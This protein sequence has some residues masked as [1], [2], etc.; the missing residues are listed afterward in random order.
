MITKH[1][2]V[3]DQMDTLILMTNLI[4]LAPV[5]MLGP[6]ALI[7]LFPL[8]TG[9]LPMPEKR[10]IR[11]GRARVIG[12]LLFTPSLLSC[13]ATCAPILFFYIVLAVDEGKLY[14]DEIWSHLFSQGPML[15]ALMIFCTLPV[16]L[17]IVMYPIAI[18]LMFTSPQ[19]TPSEMPV[20]E[21]SNIESD[22]I[23]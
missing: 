13:L 10:T 9:R 1:D 6:G 4:L 23:K 3:E 12:A 19:S 8:V 7:G 16:F 21:T 5:C 17:V 11:G 15:L 2:L 20:A 18:I 22:A 14:G